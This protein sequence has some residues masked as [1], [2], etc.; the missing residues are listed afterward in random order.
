ME[1]QGPRLEGQSVSTTKVKLDALTLYYE[2]A[3]DSAPP[4]PAVIDISLR[5]D[6][7]E[8]VAIIGPSG[9][10]KSTLLKMISGLLRPSRGSVEIDGKIVDRV[11]KGIGFL[12]QSDA[13]LPWKSAQQNIQLGGMLGGMAA[14]QANALAKSLMEDLG[15]GQALKKFPGEL[16]GGMRKRV[17][18]ARTLAYGP[19]LFLLDEPFS[20]LDAQTRIQV[21]NRFLRV[22]EK[23]GHSVVLV[24][25][26]IEEAIAM[27]D[28]VVVMTGS[29]GRIAAEFKIDL[30]HP[31][32]YYGSRFEGSFR[33]LQG[34]VWEVLR[35]QMEGAPQ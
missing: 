5:I 11:P 4:S 17:A 28:R 26:D 25:H 8:S 6:R 21:A 20:A 3:D 35:Q 12:F 27:A 22:F 18:L 14:D 15:I 16:S 1:S 7:G 34:C 29:P 23:L 30:P 19:S 10:G 24:T 32:D 31:R 2:A 9:C 13:L 33:D